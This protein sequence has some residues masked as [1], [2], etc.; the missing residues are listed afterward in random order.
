[1]VKK[2]GSKI[3]PGAIEFHTCIHVYMCICVYVC[4]YVHMYTYKSFILKSYSQS[5]PHFPQQQK[6][7]AASFPA[8]RSFFFKGD[9]FE[10]NQNQ[11]KI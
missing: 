10:M 11:M 5:Y 1:L 4:I 8:S 2:F 9:C 3:R 7:E 6:K